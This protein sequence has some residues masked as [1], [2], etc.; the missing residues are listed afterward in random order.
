MSLLDWHTYFHPQI[1][2]GYTCGL[3]YGYYLWGRRG[4]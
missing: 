1:W 2:F 4:Q 3:A